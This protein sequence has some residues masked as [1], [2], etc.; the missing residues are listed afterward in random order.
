ML[1]LIQGCSKSAPAPDVAA[2][3]GNSS[4]VTASTNSAT[5]FLDETIKVGDEER[6]YRL[7]VPDSVDANKPAPIVF[8]FHGMGG[9]SA[10]NMSVTS[11]LS[12][13]AT[14]NKFI[15]VYP[16][17]GSD[18]IPGNGFV[19]GWALSTA[20]ARSDLVFFDA[21][22]S[23]MQS[24]Y[25]IDP[26][27]I[28]LTGMSNGAYFAH[29]LGRERANE[30]AAVAAHSGELGQFD[31]GLIDTARKFPVLIIH[32]AADPVFAVQMGRDARDVYTK[33]GHPVT[34]VEIPDW[35]HA[36]DK[37]VDGQI[38]DFFSSHKLPAT[39]EKTDPKP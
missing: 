34:Y 11:G 35:G 24:R 18:F 31:L 16:E 28:Y 32:G 2:A 5:H 36:W 12:E 26:A 15:V 25:H 3:T 7:L 20:R 22:L 21:L 33:A 27:A 37:R 4:T 8:A 6:T 30:V 1:P 39:P 17:A 13:L 19:K 10:G 14:Q 23:Q 38:W 9:D 29:L